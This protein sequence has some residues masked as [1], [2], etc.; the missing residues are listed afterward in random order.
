MRLLIEGVL[1]LDPQAMLFEPERVLDPA[2]IRAVEVALG[3]RLGHEPVSRIL[4]RREFFGLD[5]LV[6]P[7]V[8][9]PRG[10]SEALVRLALRLHQDKPGPL[11][12]AD[13]GTGSGVL[14]VAFLH[15]RRQQMRDK[16]QGIALDISPT[17]LRVAARN[18]AAHALADR[19]MLAMADMARPP[20]GPVDLVLCNP[21]YVETGVIATLAPEVRDHDPSLALD[22]GPDGLAF[23]RALAA[24]LGSG[25]LVA[26]RVCLEI[27]R[28]QAEA[29]RSIMA[30]A[31]FGLVDLEHDLGGHARALAFASR[32]GDEPSARA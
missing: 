17:A 18:L 2:D 21:P 8:L 20:V 24:A 32:D 1:G 25:C 31:G 10:D 29:V 12:V 14:I 7:A 4:G 15:G 22:G 30:E 9:D 3:R 5:V 27:G 11:L 28:D 26:G 13:L 19:V 6:T 23:Y 16:D